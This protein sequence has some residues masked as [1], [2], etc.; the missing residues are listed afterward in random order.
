MADHVKHAPWDFPS[1]MIF[2]RFN[3]FLNRMLQLEVRADFC[4]CI[5]VSREVGFISY[6]NLFSLQDLFEI[7]LDFQR[8]EKLEFGGLKGKLYSEHAAQ[9]Y[10]EFSNHCQALKH[11]ENSP[12]DLNSQVK[13]FLLSFILLIKISV[14]SIDS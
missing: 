9:M 14:N 8:M 12:L 3:Q 6:Y 4:F 2:T 13:L 7:M 11:S 10:R 1:A 5:Q